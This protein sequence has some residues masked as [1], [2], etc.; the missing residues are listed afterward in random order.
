MPTA[1]PDSDL[2]LESLLDEL[3]AVTTALNEL[4]H[5]VYPAPASRVAEV[6]ARAAELRAQIS[7]R[8]RELRGA[9][10]SGA[11]PPRP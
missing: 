6:E 4:H 8:R 2:T 5:P 3:R 1:T 7:I 9:F 11:T 10:S